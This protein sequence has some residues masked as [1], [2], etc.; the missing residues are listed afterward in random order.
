MF[1]NDCTNTTVSFKKKLWNAAFIIIYF[2]NFGYEE[3][4]MVETIFVSVDYWCNF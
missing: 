2:W 1:F 3:K 4:F